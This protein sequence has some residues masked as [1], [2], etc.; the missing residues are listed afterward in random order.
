MSSGG[1]RQDKNFLCSNRESLLSAQANFDTLPRVPSGGNLSSLSRI[2]VARVRVAI[3]RVPIPPGRCPSPVP[4]TCDGVG[5]AVLAAHPTSLSRTPSLR[6]SL[7]DLRWKKS[8]SA[9]PL[10]LRACRTT[11]YRSKKPIRAIAYLLPKTSA[12][13]Y[14]ASSS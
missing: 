7:V 2:S 8:T 1:D 11:T 12:R 5:V 3:R 4:C 14:C 13:V 10:N 6:S 9:R